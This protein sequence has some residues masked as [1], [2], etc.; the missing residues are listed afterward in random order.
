MPKHRINEY[1][2]IVRKPA[3]IPTGQ[4][5]A[6]TLFFLSGMLLEVRI[7]IRIY[8]PLRRVFPLRWILVYL[9]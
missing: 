9:V 2:D 3:T 8:N 6:D 5:R 1:N 4:K 7:N